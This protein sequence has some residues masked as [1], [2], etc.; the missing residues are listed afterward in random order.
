MKK[1]IGICLLL[2]ISLISSCSKFIDTTTEKIDNMKNY[3]LQEQETEREVE[4]EIRQESKESKKTS[5]ISCIYDERSANADGIYVT[6]NNIYVDTWGIK[7]YNKITY[8][9]SEVTD[10]SAKIVGIT[11]D[12]I[13]YI[14]HG[15]TAPGLYKLKDGEQNAEYLY[16]L[17]NDIEFFIYDKYIYAIGQNGSVIRHINSSKKYTDSAEVIYKSNFSNFTNV[18]C[19]NE[20]IYIFSPSQNK[21]VQISLKDDNIKT[22]EFQGNFQ[23]RKSFGASAD[24]NR[25]YFLSNKLIYMDSEQYLY[26]MNLDNGISNK[27]LDEK[28]SDFF[29]V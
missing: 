16:D 20:C 19:Y 25:I 23:N 1:I 3:Y 2:N 12:T 13:Y 17:S 27:I 21:A 6:Q 15:T 28:V 11:E 7:Q 10:Q 9:S 5:K 8:S 4:Q 22:M 14:L 18:I 26:L 29:Y 24:H